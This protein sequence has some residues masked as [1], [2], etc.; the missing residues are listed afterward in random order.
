MDKFSLNGRLPD[1]LIAATPP[2][3]ADWVI[4]IAGGLVTNE[5]T[6]DAL[7]CI[8]NDPVETIVFHA[9]LPDVYDLELDASMYKTNPLV[10]IGGV[11]LNIAIIKQNLH[12]CT[13]FH[14][15]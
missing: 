12:S 3:P 14:Y 5:Y 11:F 6:D 4:K 10:T 7:C 2:T 9:V 8:E 15:K 1:M 13:L